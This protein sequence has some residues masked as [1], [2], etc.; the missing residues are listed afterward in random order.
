MCHYD[1]EPDRAQI[2]LNQADV[3]IAGS[4]PEKLIRHCIQQGKLVLRY[5]ERPLKNGSEWIKYLPRLVKWHWQNPPGKRIYMLCASAYTAADYARF[6]LFRGKS[7]RWGYFPET[8]RYPDLDRLFAG[9][10]PLSILWCGRFLDW[11]H[12]DDAVKV[13]AMLKRQGIPFELNMIG[14]GEIE[15]ALK[16]AIQNEGLGNCVHLLGSMTPDEVRRHMEASSIFL[17][18]S[19]RK[20]GWGAVLNEAMNSGCAVVASH[21]IGSVPF[22]LRDGENGVV[23]RSG[24]TDALCE[25]VK[26]LLLQVEKTQ[27]LGKAAYETIVEHWNAEIAAERLVCLAETLLTEKAPQKMYLEGLCSLASIMVDK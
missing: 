2:L 8:K 10:N 16:Q 15:E 17:F 24:D 20:E 12:P 11:K 1:R 25:S 18:T 6:G 26:S 3:V 22:L 4:A 19:D 5:S 21:A 13:A 14:R 7:F 27:E 23:Y 9:K